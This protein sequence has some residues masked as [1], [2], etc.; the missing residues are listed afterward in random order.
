MADIAAVEIRPGLRRIL[1]TWDLALFNIAAIVALRWLSVAAQIGPSSLVLW[2]LG[3]IGFFLPLAL[4]VLELSSRVPGEGG[5]YLWSKAAFGDLHGFV[6]GWTYWISN[7]TYLPS[8]LLF[9]AGIFLHIGGAH[10]LSHTDD[11]HYNLIYAMLV[12]W[13]ATWLSVLGLERAKWLQ[14]IGGVA[15]WAT[16]AL[17]L[18]AGAVALYRFGPATRITAANVMPD[19]RQLATFSTFATIALAFQGLELGPVLGGEIRDPDRQIPRATLIACIAIA[20]IY[21]AGTASLLIAL[22][23]STIDVIGGIPQALSAIADRIG[24]PIFGPL[25]AMLVTLGSIGTIGAWLTGMARLPFVV[26][27]DRYLPV[28]LARLHPRHGTPYMALL[29]QGVLTSLMLLAALSGSTIHEAY[30]ILIDMTVIMSLLPLTYIFLA[31][32]VLRHRS[33]RRSEGVRL[34]PLNATGCWIVGLSGF[35]V[36]LLAI[37]TSM[38]PPAGDPHPGLFLLKVV[39]GSLLLIGI[40]LMFYRH[41]D[42]RHAAVEST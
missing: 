7:I 24:L 22:P 41:R 33:A 35:A 30:I 32:P 13:S 5:L 3:L 26:G 25:T 18:V 37:V 23:A 4:A 2:L 9:S 11:S 19:F 8:M 15:T 12:L 39:G 17:I 21:I 28:V 36:T 6:T 42:R 10:W 34:A 38:I 27:V 31:F 20:A 14:N 29:I 1:G 40:G 16:G